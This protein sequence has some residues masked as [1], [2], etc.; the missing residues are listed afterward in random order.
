MALD[1]DRLS[2]VGP[3]S[4]RY[5]QDLI[6]N[7]PVGIYVCNQDAVVVAY[8]HKASEI[9]GETPMVGDPEVRFC[10]AHKLYSSDGIFIPHDQTP[11]VQVLA[12]GTPILDLDVIVERRDGT[13]RNVIANI[14]PLFDENGQ[15]IG[16]TNCIQDVTFHKQRAEERVQMISDRFQAQK[17]EVVGQLT[18]GIAHDFN[19]LLMAISGS[20]SLADHF[21]KKN[22][23]DHA[24]K[25]LGNA[26]HGA[27]AA[28][29]MTARL[30]TFSRRH[31]LRSDVI[32]VNPLIASIIELG[33]GSLGA[34]VKINASLAQDLWMTKVDPH[35]LESA[36]LN[37][38]INGRD[39]MPAGG[40]LLIESDNFEV[41]ESV[42]ARGALLV[43]G[44][45]C[46]RIRVSDNGTG[47]S[48][49]LIDR[50]F[51]PFFT[52]K[53]EGKGTGLGLAMVYGY[54]IQAAGCIN[55]QSEEG[56]GTTFS[57]FLPKAD[58]AEKKH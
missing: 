19:N 40:T 8:N 35:Q 6:E 11:M 33:R 30:M 53:G 47:M 14:T 48:Q 5:S 9:W 52:T 29:A 45:S 46:V 39:A 12:T 57:L 50:I 25:H 54:I 41:S 17:M 49:S 42:A 37:L 10:G 18:T 51:E 58:E 21:L 7:L 32:N 36:L 38:M 1:A 24:E 44:Q 28:S 31:E 16:Y 23:T 55:V 4:E 56:H 43:T 22:K 20:V 26:L 2:T 3:W 13:R 34:A 27:K 15:Q